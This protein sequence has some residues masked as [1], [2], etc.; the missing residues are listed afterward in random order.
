MSIC[1]YRTGGRD[2][3][4]SNWQNSGARPIAW[5]AWYPAQRVASAKPPE[6]GF[7][8]SDNVSLN[9]PLE[10]ISKL[11]VVLMSH[12]TGGAAESLAWLARYLA[13]AGY[14]VLAANHHRNTGLEPYTAEGLICWSDAVPGINLIGVLRLAGDGPDQDITGT[15]SIRNLKNPQSGTRSGRVQVVG[16]ASI[17]KS[18][19]SV[20]HDGHAPCQGNHLALAS[21]ALGDIG[22]PR[23][24]GIAAPAVQHNGHGLTRGTPGHLFVD[25]LASGF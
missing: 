8:L 11:P 2:K 23:A 7:F 1:G 10:G 5:A 25:I 21:A 6:P 22:C 12:G 17:R 24:Q 9:A 15:A 18:P 19:H 13:E 3:S 20:H 14:V 16:A 4:R